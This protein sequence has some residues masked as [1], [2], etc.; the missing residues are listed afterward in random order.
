MRVETIYKG[1]EKQGLGKDAGKDAATYREIFWRT[2]SKTEKH[3]N[4]LHFMA[5]NGL[6]RL[7]E[8]RIVDYANLQ[9]P[10][11]IPNEFD[12]WKHILNF[13][14]VKALQRNCIYFF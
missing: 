13:S 6:R 14:Y 11:T 8:S 2:L 10:E 9:I 12:G 7:E 4:D 5:A 1:R 3:K